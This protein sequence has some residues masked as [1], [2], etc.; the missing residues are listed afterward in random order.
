MNE[1]KKVFIN[2]PDN[3]E[4]PIGI[5]HGDLTFS[6]ILFTSNKFY[7]IDYLDSFIETPIQDIVKLRQDTKYFWS[8]MMYN[9]KYDIVRLNMIF[10]YIDYKITDY[11]G[12]IEEYYK[13]YD[14]LQLMNILRILHYVKEEKVR[15]FVLNILESLPKY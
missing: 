12:N 11:F 9:K 15:D 14:R 8:T 5:C 10:K 7:F 6:N 2:L 13:N 3:I 1:C 4:M